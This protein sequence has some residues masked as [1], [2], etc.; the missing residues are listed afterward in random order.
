MSGR[1]VVT[2]C[3]EKSGSSRLPI[4]LTT[5]CSVEFL[6]INLLAPWHSLTSVDP[7]SPHSLVSSDFDGSPYQPWLLGGQRSTAIGT[8]H[9]FS[10]ENVIQLLRVPKSLQ[11]L[12]PLYR[13]NEP[14][15]YATR[16]ALSETDSRVDDLYNHQDQTTEFASISFE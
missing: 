9:L 8:N 3:V 13:P 11:P 6:A 2:T 12:L 10:L 5:R 14:I 7:H 16:T 15:Q 1:V 4:V